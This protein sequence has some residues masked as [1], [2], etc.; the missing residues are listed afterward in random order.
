MKLSRRD[1][2]TAV[3]A[4]TL[5]AQSPPPPGGDANAALETVRRNGETLAGFDLPIETEPAFQFKP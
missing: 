4:P 1:L 3:L 5:A 2:A